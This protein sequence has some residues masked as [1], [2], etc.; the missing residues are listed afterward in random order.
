MIYNNCVRILLK[1]TRRP[2]LSSSKD[3]FAKLYLGVRHYATN[4]FDGN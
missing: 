2:L 3:T 1:L 4:Y